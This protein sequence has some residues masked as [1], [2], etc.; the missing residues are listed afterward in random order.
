MC[1]L[2][3]EDIFLDEPIPY[4]YIRKNSTRDLKRKA[5]GRRIPIAHEPLRLRF[6]E[7]VRALKADGEKHLF[8]ELYRNKAKIGGA[9]FYAI[10]WVYLINW[11]SDR[12]DM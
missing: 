9:Q 11:L 8:P 10:V 3:L 5:R 12:S 2:E 1:G 7:Y 4:I 6:D